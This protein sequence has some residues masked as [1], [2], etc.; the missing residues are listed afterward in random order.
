MCIWEMLGVLSIETVGLG[1][2]LNE[3]GVQHSCCTE[4]RLVT[5]YVPCPVFHSH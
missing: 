5:Q 2:S 4:A 3:N 1:E